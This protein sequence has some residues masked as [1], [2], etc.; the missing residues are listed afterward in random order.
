MINQLLDENHCER[1]DK[2]I[3]RQLKTDPKLLGIELLKTFD[4]HNHRHGVFHALS[5]ELTLEPRDYARAGLSREKAVDYLNNSLPFILTQ[6]TEEFNHLVRLVPTLQRQ[7]ELRKEFESIPRND[8][9]QNFKFHTKLSK[10]VKNQD[11][12]GVDLLIFKAKSNRQAILT[13]CLITLTAVYGLLLLRYIT[14]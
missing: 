11:K 1:I 9:E 6:F 3:E 4:S 5:K 2:L 8:F 12:S 13:S 14:G 10:I 7:E